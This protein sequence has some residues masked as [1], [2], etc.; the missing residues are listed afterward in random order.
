MIKLTKKQ[1][2][3]LANE[4]GALYFTGNVYTYETIVQCLSGNEAS[5]YAKKCST[6]QDYQTLLIKYNKNDYYKEVN[7]LAYSCG[8]YGNS[9]QLHEF[10]IR[11]RKNDKLIA[12]YYT[13][14]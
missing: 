2:K 6:N 11:N 1:L 14:Y 8:L 7:E 12:R 13:Y 5:D 4:L 9:G 10:I 3:E